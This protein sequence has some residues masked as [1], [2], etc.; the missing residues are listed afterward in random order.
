[1]QARNKPEEAPKKPEAAPFFLPTM[2]AQEMR[3][4]GEAAQDMLAAAAT[5]AAN[6][7]KDATTSQLKRLSE[8]T[9]QRVAQSPLL[10]LL[11]ADLRSGGD[12]NAALQWLQAASP[13]LVERELA[14]VDAVPPCEAV[15]YC[16]HPP[17]MLPS[18][19]EVFAH[20]RSA[21][22]LRSGMYF[23]EKARLAAAPD[24]HAT[25]QPRAA[26]C[27]RLGCLSLRPPCAPE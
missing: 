10:R 27:G 25:Q 8:P 6:G 15:R 22:D 16:G 3:Q 1:M 4:L 24:V 5:G 11:V 21:R 23:T 18:V 17:C 7:G 19:S 12:C 26:A 20:A 13:V 2:E 9:Q 14:C